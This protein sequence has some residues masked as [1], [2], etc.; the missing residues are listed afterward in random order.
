MRGFDKEMKAF[1]K[2]LKSLPKGK[3]NPLISWDMEY[4]KRTVKAG[5]PTVM[6]SGSF[7]GNRWKKLSPNTLGNIKQGKGRKKSDGSRYKATDKQLAKLRAQG[8]LGDWVQ[9]EPRMRNR[10][11]ILTRQSSKPYAVVHAFG[12]GNVP[13]R[14]WHWGKKINRI[15][16][17]SLTKHVSGYIGKQ[18]KR[19]FK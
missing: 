8:M 17:K 1:A 16:S 2:D 6:R 11:M 10:N 18:M 5:R 19:R 14:P 9:N 13:A 15:E 4:R 3:K 7:R 12:G